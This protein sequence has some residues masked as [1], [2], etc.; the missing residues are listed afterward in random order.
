MKKKEKKKNNKKE[1][2]KKEEEKE[3][4]EKK[5]KC[6]SV[7]F[8]Y[9]YSLHILYMTHKDHAYRTS[10]LYTRINAALKASQEIVIPLATLRHILHC[11]QPNH[12]K[13]LWSNLKR[14]SQNFA[15]S[16]MQDIYP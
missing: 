4:E 8:F 1:E 6:F 15:I 7:Y 5:K 13:Q 3:K 11:S 2:E 16:R 9:W 14:L 12:T 10:S